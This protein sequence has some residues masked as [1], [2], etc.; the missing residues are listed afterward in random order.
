MKAT[1]SY[2]T[3]FL[4]PKTSVRQQIPVTLGETIK[5]DLTWL[6]RTQGRVYTQLVARRISDNKEFAGSGK[7]SGVYAGQVG[8]HWI[9]IKID[10]NIMDF[11]L[12]L[13]GAT[14]PW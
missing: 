5:I 14:S 4:N 12:S 1:T 13:I 11:Y 10:Q 2:G 7:D 6:N 8:S 3:Y 9:T